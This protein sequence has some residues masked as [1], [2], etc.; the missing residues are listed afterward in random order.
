MYLRSSP[1]NN[2]ELVIDIVVWELMHAVVKCSVRLYL[3]SMV[4]FR[5]DAPGI[6]QYGT[7]SNRYIHNVSATGISYKQS[8]HMIY[9]ATMTSLEHDT[10]Y[11]YRVTNHDQVSSTENSFVSA[12]SRGHGPNEIILYGDMGYYDQG[13]T[14][15]KLI[16]ECM[17]SMRAPLVLHVG[18][19]SYA[20]FRGQKDEKKDNELWDLFFHRIESIANMAPYMVC[21]GNHDIDPSVDSGMQCGV[22]YIY[23]F[24]M[25]SQSDTPVSDTDCLSSYLTQVWYSFDYGLV[26]WTAISTEHDFSPGSAQYKW[27]D[28]DLQVANEDR[29]TVPFI[30]LFGHRPM[31]VMFWLV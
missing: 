18:D 27:L 15:G 29:E 23:R 1:Y 11:Y 28:A 9:R 22:G 5:L 10:K 21:A 2:L 14:T 6:V 7:V 4:C 25:P 3:S 12:P 30:I 8:P 16:V 26:H 31:Q 24:K 19:I 13:A 17:Q 20:D